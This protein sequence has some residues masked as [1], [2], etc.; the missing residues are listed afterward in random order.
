[1]A[2][3]IKVELAL[4]SNWLTC[5]DHRPIVLAVQSTL[6]DPSQV[7]KTRPR[8]MTSFRRRDLDRRNK[9][10]VSEYQEALVRDLG[11]LPDVAGLSVNAGGGLAAP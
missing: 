5:T 4:G 8:A 9:L 1:M 2:T 11:Q 3:L 7:R 6:F 10:A